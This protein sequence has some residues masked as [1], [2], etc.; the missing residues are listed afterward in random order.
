[1]AAEKDET[2]DVNE[3][4]PTV[5]DAGTKFGAFDTPKMRQE[6]YRDASPVRNSAPL[7]RKSTVTSLASISGKGA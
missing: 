3:K 7:D 4:M 6:A 2:F 1:M 5:D